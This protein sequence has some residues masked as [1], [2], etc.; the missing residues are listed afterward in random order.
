MRNFLV[1]MYQPGHFMHGIR[2]YKP[3][4]LNKMWFDYNPPYNHKQQQQQQQQTTTANNNKQTNK[5]TNK[6]QPTMSSQLPYNAIKSKIPH[7][8]FTPIDIPSNIID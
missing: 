2:I 5:Q 8:D 6:Q 3:S 7:T 1:K 4:N